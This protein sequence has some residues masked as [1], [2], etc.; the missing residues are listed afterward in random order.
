[1]PG[2]GAKPR[3][4]SSALSRASIAWPRRAAAP[5]E[6]A[7]GGDVELELDQVEAGRRLGDRVLHL[8]AGVDLEEGE[9]LLA[10]AGRGTRPC[11][12]RVPGRRDQA[13][14][15][16]AQRRVLLGVS[17]GEPDSSISFWLRRCTEQSRTPTAHTVP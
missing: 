11:R 1:M 13:H 3:S 8:E 6:P 17:A 12:R 14:G 9:G 10:R 2:A 5:L 16:V 7:A 4:A 15:G